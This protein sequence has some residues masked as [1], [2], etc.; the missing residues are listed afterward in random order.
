M[1]S[2]TDLHSRLNAY[3]RPDC[4]PLYSQIE[5]EKEVKSGKGGVKRVGSLLTQFTCNVT[6]LD[7][8]LR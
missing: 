6:W 4:I 2:S 7:T 5:V 8:W 1:Q 3:G